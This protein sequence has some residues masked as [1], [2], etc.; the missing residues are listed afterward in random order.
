V[1][2]SFVAFSRDLAHAGSAYAYVRQAFG[3]RWGFMAGWVM[4]L[5]YLAFTGATS[6]LVGNF[7][8]AAVRDMGLHLPRQGQFAG[9]ITIV[10]A[11][12]C[13]IHAMRL[14]ARPILLP[15]ALVMLAITILTLLSLTDVAG[16]TSPAAAA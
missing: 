7:V 15:E 13:V 2:L 10:I 11:L 6:A 1:G 16:A 8:D 3:R 14:A 9:V 5:A 4:L 12:Y